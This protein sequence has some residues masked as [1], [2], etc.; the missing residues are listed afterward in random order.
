MIEANTPYSGAQSETT[1]RSI[2]KYEN[3]AGYGYCNLLE[4]VLVGNTKAPLLRT[5]RSSENTS[6]VGHVT[7]NPAVKRVLRQCDI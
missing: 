4:H 5:N 7:F 3:H 1:N 6:D 2:G